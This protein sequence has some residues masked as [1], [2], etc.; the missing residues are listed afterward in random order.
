VLHWSPTTLNLAY[1]VCP[2]LSAWSSAANLGLYR[3]P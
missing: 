1:W 2:A 3:P